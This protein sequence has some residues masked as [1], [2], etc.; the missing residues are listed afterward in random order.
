MK[1]LAAAAFGAKRTWFLTNGSTGGLQAA[2]LAAVQLFHH[3]RHG[4]SSTTS[5]MSTSLSLSTT[6]TR[7]STAAGIHTAPPLVAIPRNAH[8]SII[9]ALI[10]SGAQPMFLEVTVTAVISFPSL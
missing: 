10:L 2:I 3:H 8:R 7:G 6:L 1:D 4:S 9:N 5:A